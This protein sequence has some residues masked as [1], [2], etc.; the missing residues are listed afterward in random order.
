MIFFDPVYMLMMLVTIAISGWASW[1]VKSAF[2]KYSRVPASSGLSGAQAAA[3]M[4]RKAGLEGRVSIERV[5]GFLSDHYDPRHKVLRLSPDVHDGRSLAAVGVACHEAGHAIQ[6]ARHYVPLVARNAIVP[7]AGIGSNLGVWLVIIGAI[8]GAAQGTGIGYYL[9]VTG[10]VMFGAVV[11]FQVVNLPVEF[12]ASARAKEML[13][14]M[15]VIGGQQEAAGVAR[16]LDAAAMTY[17]AATLVALL[18]MLYWIWR[19]FGNRR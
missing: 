7:M 10:I 11:L 5:Q 19:I 14:Q 2:S 9:A 16:V 3:L 17:V 4:L 6:D 12:N 8:M 15:G 1:R 18:Q 13:P